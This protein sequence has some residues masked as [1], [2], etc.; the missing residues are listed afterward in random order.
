MDSSIRLYQVQYRNE[1]IGVHIATANA[2]KQ[3]MPTSSIIRVTSISWIKLAD[4]KAEDIISIKVCSMLISLSPHSNHFPARLKRVFVKV[5][6]IKAL[7]VYRPVTVRTARELPGLKDAA[8][9]VRAV[10]SY[11]KLLQLSSS[12]AV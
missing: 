7:I 2:Y 6:C 3:E 1:R 9:G 11:Q 4:L 12:R 10:R 5:S 8:S